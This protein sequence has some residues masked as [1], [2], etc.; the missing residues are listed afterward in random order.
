MNK[1]KKIAF[2]TWLPTPYR[3]PLFEKIATWH[4]INLKIFYCCSSTSGRTWVTGLG[5]TKHCSEMLPGFNLYIPFLNKRILFNPVIWKKLSEGK[6]DCVIVGGYYPPTM[7]F[8]ILWSLRFGIPYIINSE[9][10]LL[11]IRSKWKSFLK[12]ITLTPIIR[13]A[14]AYLPLGRFQAEYLMHYG[15]SPEKMFYFPNTPDVDFFVKESDK[16]KKKK[17]KIK[18]NLKIGND[19]VVLFVGRLIEVKNLFILLQGFNEAKRKFKNISLLIVGDGPLMKSLV[20]YTENEKIEDVH[21]SGY[22]APEELPCY[23]AISDIFVLPSYSERW[24]AV[25]NE[26]MASGLP[27]VLS[28][29]VGSGGNLLEEGK[30]GF[31]FR[32]DNHKEL[33]NAFEKLLSNPDKLKEMGKESRKIAKRHGYS[34]CE[35][36]LRKALKSISGKEPL[37]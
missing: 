37:P 33:A 16:C 18:K 1:T 21:F 23:Y 2:I 19:Y 34:Y 36:N 13:K 25:V 27:I 5:K 7:T 15:A 29:K 35:V 30:N 10:Q 31:C 3:T 17:N 4:D 24:G 32:S 14:S 22:V 26:A 6:F 20:R 11:N 9:S 28:D 8:A 12:K